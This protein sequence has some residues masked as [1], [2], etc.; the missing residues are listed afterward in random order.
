MAN[1]V[2]LQNVRKVSHTD[3][4][5]DFDVKEAFFGP[6]YDQFEAQTTRRFIKVHLPIKLMPPS[7]FEVGAKIV[8]VARNPKDV[9]VSYYHFH[10][11][12]PIFHYSGDFEAFVQYFTDDLR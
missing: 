1:D 9:A 7:I 5:K 8:Y 11:Y 12:N 6:K 4:I 10:K 3:E 2:T